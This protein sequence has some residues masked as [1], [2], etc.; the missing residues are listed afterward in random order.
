[1][2]LRH[3]SVARS[4][5]RYGRRSR[6]AHHGHPEV[7]GNARGMGDRK[8]ATCLSRL[9]GQSAFSR[10]VGIGTRGLGGLHCPL[11]ARKNSSPPRSCCRDDRRLCVHGGELVD[12]LFRGG[13]LL[14]ATGWF[15]VTMVTRTHEPEAETLL[16]PRGSGDLPVLKYRIG[17]E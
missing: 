13:F 7:A 4:G 1:M 12:Q 9:P 11:R 17:L 6:S 14:I 10:Y 3:D 2:F 15:P 16:Y 5:V 8:R